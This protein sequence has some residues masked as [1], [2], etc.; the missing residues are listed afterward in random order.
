MIS[1]VSRLAPLGARRL[2]NFPRPVPSLLDRSFVS[3]TVPALA[4]YPPHTVFPMPA[5]SPTM[6]SGN[7]G[8]WKVSEGAP[9]IAGDVLCDIETDKATMDFE[10]Q[11]DGIIAKIIQPDGAQDVAVGVPVCVVVDEE[12]DVAA[13]KDFV[14]AEQDA[15]PA[16]PEPEPAPVETV[17][18]V[19]PVAPVDPVPVVASPPSPVKDL[20]SQPPPVADGPA[21]VPS[22]TPADVPTMSPVWGEKAGSSSP[23][24]YMLAARQKAY[25]DRFGSTGQKPL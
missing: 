14:V 17:A 6:E 20:P 8:T 2:R 15:A 9:F 22:N 5:L 1:T 19:A 13:F 3:R 18:T 23:L 16:A 21:D 11:D 7:I 24:A 25:V 10:A 4:D 12:E